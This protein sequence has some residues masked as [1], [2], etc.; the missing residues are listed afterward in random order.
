MAGIVS[1]KSR[2][3]TILSSVIN[4]TAVI[5]EMGL[6][7]V[8]RASSDSARVFGERAIKDDHLSVNSTK[9]KVKASI[10]RSFEHGNRN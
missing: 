1:R 5:V 10:H 2:D 4:D 9:E 3:R 8:I 7:N 6:M